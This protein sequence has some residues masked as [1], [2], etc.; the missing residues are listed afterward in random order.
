MKKIIK[1]NLYL[2]FGSKFQKETML[3]SLTMV[4]KAWQLFYKSTHKKNK[5]R[6]QLLEE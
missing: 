4:L 2:E 5:I 3:D 6:V 1:L